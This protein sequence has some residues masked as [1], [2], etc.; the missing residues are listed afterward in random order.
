MLTL[1]EAFKDALIGHTMDP[2]ATPRWAYSIEKMAR[3]YRHDNPH[4]GDMDAAREEVWKMVQMIVVEHGDRAPV[5]IN[6]MASG[7][8]YGPKIWT[9]GT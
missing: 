2:A 7:P 4:S 6:D 3:L 9:P 8:S 1:P 5:F